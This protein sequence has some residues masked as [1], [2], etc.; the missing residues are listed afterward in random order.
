MGACAH[1]VAFNENART[2]L[3]IHPQGP[4]PE[5]E[6]A[7]G[8]PTLQFKLYAPNPGLYRLYAQTQIAGQ[9][10]FAPFNITVEP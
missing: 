1:L 9:P 3:H 7:R 6:Q 4:E 2:V 8:G 5:T 10:R